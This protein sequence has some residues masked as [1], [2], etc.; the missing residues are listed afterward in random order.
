VWPLQ[1]GFILLEEV[2]G[3][4]LESEKAT[5]TTA[6]HATHFFC[7]DH[8]CVYAEHALLKTRMHTWPVDRH[9]AASY[10]PFT[11]RNVA[12]FMLRRAVL[13][14]ARALGFACSSFCNLNPRADATA[15]F[16]A[17]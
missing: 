13:E 15:I 3:G 2:P 11:T 8:A 10:Q 6:P 9:D 17:P 14:V 12:A 16:L 1:S 5:H 4:S 7:N